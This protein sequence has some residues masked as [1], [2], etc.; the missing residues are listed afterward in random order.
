MAYGLGRIETNDTIISKIMNPDL[1]GKVKVID[2]TAS[3]F[4]FKTRVD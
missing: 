1:S 4:C 2:R 3:N